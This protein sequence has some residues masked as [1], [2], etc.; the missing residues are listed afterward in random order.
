MDKKKNSFWSDGTE[1]ETPYTSVKDWVADIKHLIWPTII[2][3]GL[4]IITIILI[5]ILTS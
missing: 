4:A 3:I 5:S 2:L 1:D